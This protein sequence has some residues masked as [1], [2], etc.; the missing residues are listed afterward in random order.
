MTELDK[1]WRSVRFAAAQ[2]IRWGSAS[3]PNPKATRADVQCRIF[4]EPKLDVVIGARPD[5]RRKATDF[6]EAG[7]ST[8]LNGDIDT[9]KDRVAYAV[10]VDTAGRSPTAAYVY[11][12]ETL[13]LGVARVVV[14]KGHVNLATRS[15]W[16]MAVLCYGKAPIATSIEVSH[17]LT[18]GK[19]CTLR[20]WAFGPDGVIPARGGPV[21]TGTLWIPGLGVDGR[22]LEVSVPGELTITIPKGAK[23][24]SYVCTLSGTGLLG[25]MR[26]LE[27]G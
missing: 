25:C 22:G 17:P 23:R 10:S 6:P 4:S 7:R 1:L 3:R 14:Q 18:P 21:T 12:V 15:N 11:D 2:T 9:R 27:V 8:F 16:F 24:G 13:R 5:L 19:R 26:F 20:I